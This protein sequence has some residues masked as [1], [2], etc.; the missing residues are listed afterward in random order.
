MNLIL[1]DTHIEDFYPFTFTR[2]VSELR[3]GAFTIAQKW[4]AYGKNLKV[5]YKTHESLQEKFPFVLEN[6]NLVVPSELVPTKSLVS[7]VN[8]LL[9]NQA[10]VHQGEILAIRLGAE[11]ISNVP[12]ATAIKDYINDIEEIEYDGAVYW[13]EQVTD[14][15]TQAGQY[16]TR[17]I[18]LFKGKY[19]TDPGNYC[20]VLGKELIIKKGAEVYA[21]TINTTTGPVVIDKGA[22]VMEGCNLRGPLYIGEGA[23]VKMGAKIYGPTVIGPHCKV[24]GEIS[25]S[26]FFGYSNKGHDGFLGNSI[27]GEWCNLGADTNTSNL[28]NNYGEVKRWDYKTQD[29]QGSGLQFCGLLM[30]DH[31]KS[32][33]NTQFNTGT[34]VGVFANVFTSKFPPK[35][36]KSFA[37]MGED[38]EDKFNLEK[39]YEVALRVMER[40]EVP[41]T[42][43]DKRLL[44][45][46]YNNAK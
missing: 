4:K 1:F 19:N 18:S 16:L 13:L 8:D 24:G 17:D 38:K 21:S 26:I 14:L 40:R 41:L 30:G 20:K 36:I 29:Y 2:P 25:N 28:K 34:T 45:Y 11:K 12:G 22:L 3:A 23:V 7:K 27:I 46:L 6:D 43:A 9:N 42:D 15:F 39:A 10:L 32:A 35:H 37:W 44:E 31:S 33:I 5:C